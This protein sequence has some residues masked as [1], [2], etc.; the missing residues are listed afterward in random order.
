MLV[1][2]ADARA[3]LAYVRAFR[4]EIAEAK[5]AGKLSPG[6]A[7]P[8]QFGQVFEQIMAAVDA[9]PSGVEQAELALQRSPALQDWVRYH[10]RV[11][12]WVVALREDGL[13]RP[14]TTDPAAQRFWR[15]LRDW[16]IEPMPV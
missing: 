1:N 3:W 16:A 8:P 5:E 6:L 9:L 13:L 14:A 11:E 2:V 4:R 10:D 15:A 7:A 12:V